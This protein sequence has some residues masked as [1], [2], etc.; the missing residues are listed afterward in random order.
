[1]AKIERWST[2][3]QISPT[4]RYSSDVCNTVQ[5]KLGAFGGLIQKVDAGTKDVGFD[6]AYD[7]G[8][9]Q[10]P[11]LPTSIYQVFEKY[12][13][14]FPA[15]LLKDEKLV[16]MVHNFKIDLEGG[17]PPIYRRLYKSNL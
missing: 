12:S 2:K 6:S 14:I 5:M 9:L 7:V 4:P 3:G 1:M 13:N 15:E 17:T 16:R 10:N 11:N 8:K